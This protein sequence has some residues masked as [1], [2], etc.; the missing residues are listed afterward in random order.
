[1]LV[2]ETENT[3]FADIFVHHALSAPMWAIER[4]IEVLLHVDNPIATVADMIYS[5]DKFL[6]NI[7]YAH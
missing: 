2:G 3:P 4:S 7:F 5:G 1:M 6:T